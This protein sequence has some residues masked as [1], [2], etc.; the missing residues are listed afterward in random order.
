MIFIIWTTCSLST[1]CPWP[2]D[3]VIS[4]EPTLYFSD[5]ISSWDLSIFGLCPFHIIPLFWTS[6][7]H[8]AE[9]LLNCRCE[10]IYQGRKG[11]NS[12]IFYYFDTYCPFIQNMFSNFMSILSWSFPRMVLMHCEETDLVNRPKSHFQGM[13]G[14]VWLIFTYF[15]ILI[16]V[17]K[18]LPNICIA[19]FRF[20]GVILV[21]LSNFNGFNVLYFQCQKGPIWT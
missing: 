5:Q 17:I 8:V 19:S 12:P 10:V 20:S 7:W 21:L 15:C 9:E 11:L 1:L 18:V 6:L 14:Q 4:T 16:S 13:K 3:M 2:V